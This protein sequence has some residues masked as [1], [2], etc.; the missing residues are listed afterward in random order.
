MIVKMNLY[1]PSPQ[2]TQETIAC[3]V[4]VTMA[5]WGEEGERSSLLLIFPTF[6]GR[7]G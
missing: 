2:E 4:V 6:W 7:Y 1:S 5:T 3:E